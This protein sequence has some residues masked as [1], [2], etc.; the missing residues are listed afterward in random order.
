MDWRI[1]R[2]RVE[3]PGPFSTFPGHERVLVVTSGPG[4]ELEHG[5]SSP[6]AR[7]RPL[8]P[9]RFDG[10][11]PTSAA[12]LG[13]PVADFN[14]VV[15]RAWGEAEVEVLRLGLRNAREAVGPGHAFA[16]VLAGC[17]TAR[18][19]GEEEPFELGSGDSLWV[20]E[21]RGGEELDLAGEEEGTVVLLVR[22]AP[23]T[24]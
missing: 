8:E 15:R 20:R 12:L 17:A 2:A 1:S 10:D 23:A 18:V 19:T 22:L 9:Y 5:A 6:R 16:H 21:L 3:E 11:W 24:S 13:G 14:V 4:L 7:L